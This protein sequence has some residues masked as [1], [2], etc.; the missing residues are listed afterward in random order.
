MDLLKLAGTLLSSDSVD[1]LSERT[2]SSGNDVS[3]V[4]TKALPVLLAG[5]NTQAKDES[6]S[7]GFASA[8]SDHAKDDTSNL[9]KFLGNV[10]MADGAKIITHLLGSGEDDTVSEIADDSGVDKANTAAILSA[11][12]PLLLSLLGQQTEKEDSKEAVGDLVGV[13]LDNVD[14]ASVLTGL[15][16]S[17]SAAQ[18]EEAPKKTS[19]KKTS[20]KK[21]STSKTGTKKAASSKSSTKKSGSTSS[22]KSS[23]KKS[24]STSS[25]KS[26]TKKTSTKKAASTKSS[27]KASSS[28]KK[29]TAK[30]KA[31]SDSSGADLVTGLLKSL[32]K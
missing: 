1:G 30:K 3:S 6:S 32:L 19:T 24:G 23:T 13:L 5:A 28:T 31:A 10:D 27:T 11:A 29:S 8:L 21:A 12:A 14:V 9:S 17:N 2:G 20:T 15:L 18:E 16:T 22:S 26:S 4:L 7:K 25:S